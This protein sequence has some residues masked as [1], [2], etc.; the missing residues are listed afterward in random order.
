M[1]KVMATIYILMAAISCAF[2]V[3][4]NVKDYGAIANGSTNNTEI[5][6]KALD[7][8]YNAGGGKVH[9]P[10]GNYKI[11]SHLRIPPNTTLEGEWE[12]PPAP[13]RLSPEMKNISP[14]VDM[15]KRPLTGT[16]LLAVEGQGSEGGLS[17]I[18]M[19]RNSTLKGITIY[20]PEQVYH[21][22]PHAYPW[23]VSGIGDNISIIDC[24]FVNPYNAV[25]F[26]SNPCGRHLIRNL[27][28]QAI[29]KGV[30]I[31]KCYDVGRLE[32]IH[33]WPFWTA[34]VLTGEDTKAISEWTEKHGTAFILSRS[35]WEYVSNCFA[36][37]YYQGFHFKTSA[38]DGPGNYLFSQSGA[39]GC[40]I[41][42]NFEELQAH[43][44][45]SFTNSQMFGR[46]L[47]GENN[48][49][50]IR[51]S[52][53][54]F[55]GAAIVKE[56]PDQEVIKVEGHGRISFDNCHFYAINGKT[57]TPVFIR[58]TGGRLNVNNSLYMVN[59]FLDPIPLV[60]EEGAIST[61]YAQNELYTAKRVVNNK[62][63]SSRVIIKDNIYSD[64][65]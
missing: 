64:T 50:P 36:I 5:F 56:K 41:A 28:A 58:Q 3:D 31:D 48:H 60:V 43:S 37:S 25:D 65:K 1:Y 15:E 16:V 22:S 13:S 2:A 35:D 17:F 6:Q 42:A 14:D 54:G 53:C 34:H 32:N 44:G 11:H 29:N 63:K 7:D 61:V 47:T 26:G 9:V 52:S 38:P 51:F 18:T 4:L 12:A 30:F 59:V 49:A 62:K 19:E 10:A 45:V 23:T 57:A 27:Y 46:I 8:A 20:Y 33:L 39:D 21:E 55:F 40:D 24:L